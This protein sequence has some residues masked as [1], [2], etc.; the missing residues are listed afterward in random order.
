MAWT[1]AALALVVAVAVGLAVVSGGSGEDPRTPVGLAGMAPPFLGTAAAGSG[2]LTAAVDAYGDVVD[3][4]EG[5]AGRALIDNPSDRQAAGTVPVAT[6]VVPRVRIG[7]GGAGGNVPPAQ[8]FWRADSVAQRYLRGTNVVRTVARFG[9]VRV[10]ETVA[11]GG[12]GRGE[13]AL[14]LT[15][16]A[17]PGV[18]ARAEVGTNFAAGSGVRCVRDGGAAGRWVAT[19]S[20]LG[21]KKSPPTSSLAVSCGVGIPGGDAGQVVREAV[22][23][24]RGWVARAAPLGVGAPGWAVAMYGRSLLTLRA[25]TDRWT[26]AVAAGARDGWAYVWPR[27]AGTAA[28]GYAAAGYRGEARRVAGFL[29]GLD[30]DA[31]ARFDGAGA[32][33]PGRGPQG[34][35]AAWVS[36]A[37]QAAAPN[38]VRE[39]VRHANTGAAS[40]WRN[41]PDYQESA[42][43]DYLANAIAAGYLKRSELAGADGPKTLEYRGKS[44]RRPRSSAPLGQFKASGGLVRSAGDPGSGL[45]SAAAWAV[46]PFADPASFAAVRRTLLRLAAGQTR[47]GITPGEAWDEADPWTAPTAWSAWSLAALADSQRRA[48]NPAAANVDR[49]Q[50][51][52]L[53]ADL[54][55]AATPA[56]AF[57]ERVDAR[58]GVPRSTTPLAWPH[59]FAILA[60]RQLWP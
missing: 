26:G 30:L 33:V 48:G 4:R 15:V 10:V 59:A 25:L 22:A 41:R 6:G 50:S 7:G 19:S 37:E 14:G 57:P 5:P 34:D 39:R 23:A 1:R 3:L 43:G 53:L 42:P 9:R 16:W 11:V 56:G 55:R 54:R 28:L 20:Y 29:S 36:I 2:G 17:P 49:R 58:T 51:L 44:A 40:P 27:D 31:A 8:P 12:A 60:L 38:R 46:R 52:R 24:D 21:V 47:F 32:P 35:A 45:D 13:L 18:R